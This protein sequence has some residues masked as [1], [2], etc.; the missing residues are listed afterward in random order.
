MNF[1][2]AIALVS[3]AAA[4]PKTPGADLVV[5]NA[6]LPTA[7]GD[8]LVIRAGRV[9]TVTSQA[10]LGTA[11][12]SNTQVIDAG[13][14]VLLP[15]F[16]DSHIHF[17]SGG[18]SEKRVRVHGA[19][20]VEEI[21][22]R[23]KAYAAAHPEAQWIQGRGFS[24]D[25]FA[26]LKPAFPTR[27]MLDAAV[28]DRPVFIRAYDG[29]TG[30]ANTK[31]LE[32]A[33]VTKDTKDPKDGK[34]IREADGS[35]AGALLEG[36]MDLM[37]EKVPPYSLAERIEGILEA[38]RLA[39]EAG[40]TAINDFV[41][42]NETLDAYLAL[43]KDGRLKVRVFFSPPIETPLDEAKAL[44]DRIAKESKRVKF[45]SLKGFVDGVVESNTAAFIA[46]YADDHKHKGEAH[47]KPA[48]LERLIVPA[49]KEGF[50]VSLHAIGDLAVRTSL[51]AYALAAQKNG[52]KDRRHRIEH[53]E[54]LDPKDAK[55]FKE[56]GVIASMQP[57]H[58]EPAD[59]PGKGVWEIKVGKARA[60]YIFP[61]NEIRSQ[62]GVVAFGSDWSVMSLDPLMGL[63]VA[64]TRQN[65]HGLPR[66][67]WAVKQKLS[68][69]EA[70]QA[71]TES[72]AYA[73]H[74]EGELGCLAAGCA[75]DFVLLATKV[76][77]EEPLSL[78]WGAV[79]AT[80]IDG[81]RAF[82]R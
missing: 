80:Y 16:I 75:A 35:P 79:D 59:V 34:I 10:K 45:G 82:G 1:A 71:Y 46:P 29:H 15:G 40:L 14:R 58:A 20:N 55:R 8:A 70:V 72:A 32:L 12:G 18:I 49:D 7:D 6:K 2:L 3:A 61:W 51:D 28:P 43:E 54:V 41:A 66:E 31:A 17:M 38:Q 25:L 69:K 5:I 52:T 64:T 13:G 23:I 74:A 65:G 53:I 60:P 77:P 48:D 78:Y 27:Q 68:F 67:G 36:A 42:D 63:A 11:V 56:L 47:L 37:F 19:K 57:Y 21:Q 62:G 73:L 50:V 4:P 22:A 81:K 26:K 44:R 30:W 76:D 24:Y 39:L 33:G 9:A